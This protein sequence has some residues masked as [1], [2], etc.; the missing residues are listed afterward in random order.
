MT[1]VFVTGG[2]GFI[3]RFLV[4][5]LAARGCEVTA[6]VRRNPQADGPWPATARPVYG[7]ILEPDVYRREI[8][9]ADYV[10]HLAGCLRSPRREDFWRVNVGG[11]ESLLKCCADATE[12]PRTVIVS[13]L[14]AVGPSRKR[15]RIEADPPQP[16]SDYGRSKLDAERLAAGFADRVPITIVRPPIVLGEGDMMGLKMFTSIARWGLHLHPT[17][18]RTEYSVIHVADL[19]D[20]LWRAA[21]SDRIV[22]ADCFRRWD[23]SARSANTGDAH[24]R[25]QPPLSPAGDADRYDGPSRWDSDCPPLAARSE[26]AGSVGVLAPKA[27]AVDPA[28]V[29]F[30]AAEALTYADLGRQIAAALGRRRVLVL[31]VAGA[32]IR[33]AGAAGGW[34]GRICRRP[35]YLNGDKAREIVAGSWVCSA[36][37]ARR[38][39]GFSP[40]PLTVRLRETVESYRKA[41]LVR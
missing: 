14:A 10:F 27:A 37:K 6:L 39:L 41:G 25:A 8:Q 32:I 30:A 7:D 24:N 11:L 16:V 18:R 4:R 3:G 13:S 23:R 35:V 12:P 1:R 5:D 2:S 34:I 26:A 17:L 19:A 22:D 33:C 40:Q 36:D 21:L 38:Q 29:F 31:P 15:P 28:G 9:E 20:L